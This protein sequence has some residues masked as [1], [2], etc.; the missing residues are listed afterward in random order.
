VPPVCVRVCVC[1]ILVYQLLKLL[2]T[3]DFAIERML[4]SVKFSATLYGKVEREVLLCRGGNVIL[5]I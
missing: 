2:A 1:A 5:L 4:A 3:G